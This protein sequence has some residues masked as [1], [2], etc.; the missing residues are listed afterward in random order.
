M[1]ACKWLL[2]FRVMHL[3]ALLRAFASSWAMFGGPVLYSI[4]PPYACARSAWLDPVTPGA[5][6]F[7]TGK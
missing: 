5:Y 4:P 7:T 2:G 1:S 3:H 6:A